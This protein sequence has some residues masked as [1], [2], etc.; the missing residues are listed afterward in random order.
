MSEPDKLD[1]LM[2]W[3]LTFDPATVRAEIDVLHARY[4]GLERE[5]LA[6]KI[7]TRQAWKAAALGFATGLPGNLLIA[8]PAGAADAVAMLRLEASA[9]VKVATIYE[10]EYL[11]DHEPQYEL[12]VPIFGAGVLSQA[13]REAGVLAGREATR[14]II[15]KYL[16]K[17]TLKAF[18]SVLLKVFGKRVLQRT[19][20]TKTVPIVGGVIGA[21]WNWIE[22]KLQGKRVIRYFA[23]GDVTD[24]G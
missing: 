7:Y 15:R 2:R 1:K 6:R 17:G 11:D 19:V 5:E 4:P 23:E 18:Q 22:I 9:A 21:G 12:L 3:A 8:L 24:E 16:S 13:L 20:I 14:R 10:P